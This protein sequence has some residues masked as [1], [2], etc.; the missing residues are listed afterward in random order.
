MIVVVLIGSVY[1]L[2]LT[3]FNKKKVAITRL[4]NIKD[5]L[6]PM[7]KKGVRVDLI[8]YNKCSQSVIFIN[9]EQQEDIES[10]LKSKLFKDITIYKIDSTNDTTK[11]ELAPIIFDK[12]LYEVCFKFTLFP[13]GSSSSYIVEQN[14]RF[15]IFYPYFQDPKIFNSLEEAVDE[16]QLK[17]Y[18]E[19]TPHEAN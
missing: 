2:V 18:M 11:V 8:I 19:I 3:G 4:E 16:Y 5:T 12:K 6:L 14:R 10:S 15:Y 7:W 9:N 17:K 1:A 13:N